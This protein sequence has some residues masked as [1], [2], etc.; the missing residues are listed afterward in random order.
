M[1]TPWCR[2]GLP[3][4]SFPAYWQSLGT[5]PVAEVLLRGDGPLQL[6]LCSVHDH[7]PALFE[8][9]AERAVA[10]AEAHIR[11]AYSH[12]PLPLS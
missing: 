11:R 6:L 1:E 8:I 12:V 5:P 2:Y 10:L 4:A 7:S 3:V 9:Y